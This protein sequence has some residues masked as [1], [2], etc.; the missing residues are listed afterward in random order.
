MRK[1]ALHIS[2]QGECTPNQ[3][4]LVDEGIIIS[5]NSDNDNFGNGIL[6]LSVPNNTTSFAIKGSIVLL[7]DKANSPLDDYSNGQMIA[8]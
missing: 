3:N 4:L 5:C 8:T 1:F 6:G 2:A 7:N